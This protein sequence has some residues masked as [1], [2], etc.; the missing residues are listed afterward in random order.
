LDEGLDIEFIMD[1]NVAVI[2]AVKERFP[3][4]TILQI[5]NH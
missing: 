1:D 4:I 3:F 2:E 5:A